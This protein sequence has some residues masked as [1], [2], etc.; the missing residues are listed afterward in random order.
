MV[1]FFVKS[2]KNGVESLRYLSCMCVCGGGGVLTVFFY[3]KS[4]FE[5]WETAQLL[6]VLALQIQGP[7][8]EPCVGMYCNPGTGEAEKEGPQSLVA[9]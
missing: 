9:A 7:E 6:K 8:F 5:G 4:N 1:P 2:P 3:C